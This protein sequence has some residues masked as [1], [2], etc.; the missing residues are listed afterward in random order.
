VLNSEAELKLSVERFW[1]GFDSELGFVEI[2][3]CVLEV[4]WV[5]DDSDLTDMR[6]K[7]EFRL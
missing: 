1:I 7:D 4:F 6:E 2:V 3:H 5:C